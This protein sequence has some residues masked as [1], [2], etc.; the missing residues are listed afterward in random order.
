MRIRVKVPQLIEARVRAG[1]SQR[2]LARAAGISSGYMAQIEAGTHDPSP[3]VAK[4]LC[5]ALGLTFDDLFDLEGTAASKL[6][7]VGTH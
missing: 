4:R 5:D 3:A 1:L 7:A 6:S 2:A